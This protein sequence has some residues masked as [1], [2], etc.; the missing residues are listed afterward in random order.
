MKD[1]KIFNTTEIT[2]KT[3]LRV[4]LFGDIKISEIKELQGFNIFY[5]SPGHED[6]VNIND[7]KIK[8][9][10]RYIQVFKK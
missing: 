10:V 8:R 3:K 4:D 6:L 2:D 9:K 7:N 5:L 1:Y